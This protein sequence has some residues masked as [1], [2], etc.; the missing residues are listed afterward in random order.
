MPRGFEPEHR[1]LGIGFPATSDR[2]DLLEDTLEIVIR[3]MSGEAVSYEGK[4]TTLTSATLRPLPVQRPHPPIWI[5]GHGPKRTLPLAA[6][7]ADMWHDF[8][9]PQ[10]YARISATV[11]S[12]ATEAGRDPASI[13]RASSLSIS[14]GWDEV[15]E[16]IRSLCS[17]RRLL[18]G[19]RL[20]VRRARKGRR[21]RG[22]GDGRVPVND[23]PHATI[24]GY[25]RPRICDWKIGWPQGDRAASAGRIKLAGTPVVSLLVVRRASASARRR[26]PSI[27]APR[28]PRATRMNVSAVPCPEAT[29]RSIPTATQLSQVRALSGTE[30]P[31]GARPGQQASRPPS[32]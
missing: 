24:L 29:R 17:S 28:K 22:R 11:D 21:V 30:L 8:A 3:L 23:E 18:P 19:V 10:E 4:T 26:H 14:E 6:C 27:V 25:S 32:R 9:S 15:R 16:T 13:G 2:F 5:G 1:A 20:A 31:G 12:L 7:Y